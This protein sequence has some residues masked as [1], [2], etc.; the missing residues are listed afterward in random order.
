MAKHSKTCAMPRQEPGCPVDGMQVTMAFLFAVLHVLLSLIIFEYLWYMMI[1][2]IYVMLLYAAW[3]SQF[4]LKFGRFGRRRTARIQLVEASAWGAD[5]RIL[6]MPGRILLWW[7][8]LRYVLLKN[9]K[10]LNA[11][12][13]LHFHGSGLE[14]RINTD[15]LLSVC[16]CLLNISYTSECWMVGF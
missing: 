6:R 1:Y 13:V 3:F 5:L 11:P 16:W 15:S 4:S 9:Q 12:V 7:V 2:V 14:L 10:D 8:A